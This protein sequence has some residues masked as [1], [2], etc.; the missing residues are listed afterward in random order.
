MHCSVIVFAVVF[1]FDFFLPLEVVLSPLEVGGI[2]YKPV[3][4]FLFPMMI[5]LLLCIIL[6]WCLS[7]CAVQSLS[8][9]CPTES[10]F[11]LMSLKP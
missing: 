2:S 10:K 4:R 6:H 11:V 5:V 3:L 8:H 1:G 7:K 9:H